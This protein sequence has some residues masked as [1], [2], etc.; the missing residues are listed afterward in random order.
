V[1]LAHE[2]LQRWLLDASAAGE[3]H[4]DP[5]AGHRLLAAAMWEDASRPVL[6]S[7]DLS[8]RPPEETLPRGALPHEYTL[9]NAAAHLALSGAGEEVERLE[10]LVLD[11]DFMEHVYAAGGW[12]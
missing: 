3:H 10:R 2:S 5:V 8:L 1:H 9:R 7:M 12:L 4:A 11:F 6:P